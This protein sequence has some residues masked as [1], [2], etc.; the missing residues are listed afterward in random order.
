MSDIRT[1][2]VTPEYEAGWDY[3]EKN[4]NKVKESMCAH[5]V[6]CSYPECT[7]GAK[8]KTKEKCEFFVKR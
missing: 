4:K 7:Y 3:Y 2:P 6:R 5:G 8:F 1:R